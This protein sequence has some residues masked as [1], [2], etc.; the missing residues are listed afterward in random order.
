MIRR[1]KV[2]FQPQLQT[3]DAK[4]G[5]V[6]RQT[7]D[8]C[9]GRPGI[10]IN[11][12]KQPVAVIIATASGCRVISLRQD[13]HQFLDDERIRREINTFASGVITP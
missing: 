13:A 11:A 9:H 2:W 10:G 7:I 8:G 6:I 4:V 1:E 3:G 5:A 12:Y